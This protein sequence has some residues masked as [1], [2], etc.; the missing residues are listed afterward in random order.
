M[1]RALMVL[2]LIASLLFVGCASHR[3]PIED[4]PTADVEAHAEK[5]RWSPDH[6]FSTHARW[7]KPDWWDEHP[8]TATAA[9]VAVGVAVAAAVLGIVYLYLR[10][11][12]HDDN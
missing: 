9:S 6:P 8:V 1:P 5:G 11:S 3:P 7:V 2:C 10:T 4:D 12:G